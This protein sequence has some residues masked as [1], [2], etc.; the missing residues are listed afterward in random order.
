MGV[1]TT[2]KG[3]IRYPVIDWLRNSHSQTWFQ[4]EIV[5]VGVQG[6]A[7]LKGPSAFITQS[8]IVRDLIMEGF[9]CSYVR[10][11]PLVDLRSAICDKEIK[12]EHR[13]ELASNYPNSTNSTVPRFHS[14][15]REQSETLSIS[16]PIIAT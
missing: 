9:Y 12:Y 14:N 4:K 16:G 7:R 3:G 11:L 5:G 6:W 2:P 15:I 1:D 8:G 13:V 10:A